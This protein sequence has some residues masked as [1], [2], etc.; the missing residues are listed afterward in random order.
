MDLTVNEKKV[1][2]DVI[3]K[4]ISGK[5]KVFLY[6]SRARDTK[7]LESDIDILILTNQNI[8][9]ETLRKIKIE[10]SDAL[11]GTKVDIVHS[12]FDKKNSFV[13]LIEDNAILLWERQ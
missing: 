11:A 13:N 3:S 2:I 9:I 7:N 12:I 6:G 1:I 10:I 4:S 8:R 5:V